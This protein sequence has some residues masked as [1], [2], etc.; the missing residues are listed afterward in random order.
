MSTLTLV[1]HGQATPFQRETDVLS[2]VGEQQASALARYWTDSGI[3]FDEVYTGTL[4]RQ[5]R[6][7]ELAGAAMGDWPVAQSSVAWNEYDAPGVLTCFVPAL[8]SRDERFA[9]LVREFEEARGTPEQNRRFQ[10]MFEIAMAQW[11]EG[12]VEVD[13]VEPFHAFRSRVLAA[14][15][16]LMGAAKSKRVVVFT[17]GGPIGLM[18]QHVLKAPDRSFLDVNWRV[19]NCSITEFVFGGGRI[20]LDSF[21]SV[22]HLPEEWRTFR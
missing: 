6:T 8:A 12:G 2:P 5:Q 10:R 13:G 3:A 21:N 14:L 16:A 11:L 19:K 15:S 7:E 18:V 1:R 4:V 22:A 9:E 17:S 20:S